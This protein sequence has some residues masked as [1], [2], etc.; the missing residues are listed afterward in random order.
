MLENNQIKSRVKQLVDTLEQADAI[1]QILRENGIRDSAVVKH[2]PN[3]LINAKS[4]L[5]QWQK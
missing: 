3:A 4:L 1:A 5:R 2:V